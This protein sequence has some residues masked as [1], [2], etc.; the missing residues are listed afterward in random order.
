METIIT[1]LGIGMAI[2]LLAGLTISLT[3]RKERRD[4]AF[5][6]MARN[7]VSD[8]TEQLERQ[9]RLILEQGVRLDIVELRLGKLEGNLPKEKGA[10]IEA[11]KE[12]KAIDVIGPKPKEYHITKVKR[13][14]KEGLSMTELEA[15]KLLSSGAL[16]PR[17]IQ[18]ALGRSREHTARLLKGLYEKKYV[19]RD[20]NKKPYVYRLTEKGEGIVKAV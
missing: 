19:I 1:S 6:D 11:K 5:I 10:T 4:K 13:R 14:S 7:L 3:K 8:I 9:E 18:R 16:T 2:G 12:Q 17:D 15:L 20:E